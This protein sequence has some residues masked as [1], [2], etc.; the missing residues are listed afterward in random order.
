MLALGVLGLYASRL[1]ILNRYITDT[2][3]RLQNAS[4]PADQQYRLTEQLRVLKFQRDGII[5][6][7]Y[8]QNGALEDGDGAM[9]HCVRGDD[10]SCSDGKSPV[11]DASADEPGSGRG[12]RK[13]VAEGGHRKWM[14]EE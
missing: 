2:T 10:L 4:I 7:D 8:F 1:A 13:W 11:Q 5:I 6:R 3:A 12:H 9:Y 14:A